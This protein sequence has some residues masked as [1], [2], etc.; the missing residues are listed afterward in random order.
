M[1]DSLGLGGGS[2]DSGAVDDID[3]VDDGDINADLNTNDDVGNGSFA[4]FLAADQVDGDTIGD[5]GN[6]DGVGSL[7]NIVQQ[8]E[9]SSAIEENSVGPGQACD[10][11]DGKDGLDIASSCDSSKLNSGVSGGSDLC[12]GGSSERIAGSQTISVNCECSWW[13]HIACI[14]CNQLT[15]D[16]SQIRAGCELTSLRGCGLDS[17]E[18]WS[19]LGTGWGCGR[20]C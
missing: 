17:Q 7:D 3:N 20:R 4:Y 9:V 18:E 16:H 15:I 8:A 14:G 1:S 5:R 13:D 2:G 19:R 11:V 6:G 10:S 12:G